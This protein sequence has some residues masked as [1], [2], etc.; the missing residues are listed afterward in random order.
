MEHVTDD[1]NALALQGLG[2]WM[3]TV[4]MVSKRIKIEQSLTGMAVLTIATIQHNS[5]FTC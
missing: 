5:A 4:K 3:A 2:L 1:H